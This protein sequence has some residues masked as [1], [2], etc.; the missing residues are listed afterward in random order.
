M[1][2]FAQQGVVRLSGPEARDFL[3]GQTTRD[4][5]RLEGPTPLLFL[6]PKGQLE[7][8]ATLFPTPEAYLLAPWGSPEGLFSR[9]QRYIVFD[10]VRLELLPLFY[11]WTL[12]KEWLEEAPQEALGP[13]DWARFT[14]ERGLP[15]LLDLKGEL[16]QVGGLEALVDRGKG[17]YV[18]QEIMAR[19][20]GKA[21]HHRL[22]DLEVL[23]PAPLG[24]LFLEGR[25]VGRLKRV[26]G[27]RARGVVRK[28]VPFKAE[29]SA[30]EGR[31]VPVGEVRWSG[32]RL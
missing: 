25:E 4:V 3:Q 11:L 20:E 17:C 10:Q 26:E 21:V 18:G 27:K 22:V 29:L 24:P 31:F 30:G 13:G 23:S 12:E 7:E 8:G 6:N 15:H 9:L 32:R 16:P 19:T 28:E 1:E 2:V 5:R 14:L